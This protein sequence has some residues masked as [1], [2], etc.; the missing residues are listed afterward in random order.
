MLNRTIVA[1]FLAT[2][3]MAF[4]FP[5]A[6]AAGP[7]C[8]ACQPLPEQ[9]DRPSPRPLGTVDTPAPADERSERPRT[10]RA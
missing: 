7:R 5:S 10:V 2:S 4:G 9:A 8:A 3:A 1:A 6:T